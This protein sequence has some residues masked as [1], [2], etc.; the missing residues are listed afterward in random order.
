M[1]GLWSSRPQQLDTRKFALF[2]TQVKEEMHLH[3]RVLLPRAVPQ[4]IVPV[5]SRGNQVQLE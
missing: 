5:P 1:T 2:L 3:I 4:A